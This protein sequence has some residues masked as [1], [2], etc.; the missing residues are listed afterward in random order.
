MFC[1]FCKTYHDHFQRCNNERR[2]T[3]MP[4]V[5]L[6]S[7]GKITSQG[8]SFEFEGLEA[9]NRQ[10]F[11]WENIASK[12]LGVPVEAGN[13]ERIAAAPE[14]ELPD[15][16]SVLL[17]KISNEHRIVIQQV[18]KEERDRITKIFKDLSEM[19]RINKS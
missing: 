8:V 11:S 7:I 16:F 2:Q 9:F 13:I 6:K 10:W 3:H 1:V 4:K 17:D 15:Y 18:V 5:I 14:K 12:I 19:D